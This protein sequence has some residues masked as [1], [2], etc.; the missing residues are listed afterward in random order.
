MG[1]DEAT[2][3]QTLFEYGPRYA[4][5]LRPARLN[6]VNRERQAALLHTLD[7]HFGN[8]AHWTKPEGG[9]FVWLTLPE[10]VDTWAM[11]DAA[12]KRQVAY[13]PGAAFAVNGGHRNALRLNYSNVK[14]EAIAEGIKRLAAVVREQVTERADARISAEGSGA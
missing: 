12:V 10:S 6:A 14:L 4:R 2:A 9:L 8:I 11:F 13:V 1:R 5:I 3:L 7:E